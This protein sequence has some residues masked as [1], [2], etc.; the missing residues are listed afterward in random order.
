[1]QFLPTL[2]LL[3]QCPDKVAC[4]LPLRAPRFR[5]LLASAVNPVAPQDIPD[6]LPLSEFVDSLRYIASVIPM[7]IHLTHSLEADKTTIDHLSIPV[8]SAFFQRLTMPV[9]KPMTPVDHGCTPTR[10]PPVP[11]DFENIAQHQDVFDHS[12]NLSHKSHSS[13][14]SAGSSSLTGSASS[15]TT[16]VSSPTW[17]AKVSRTHLAELLDEPLASSTM[18]TFQNEINQLVN[19]PSAV[20]LLSLAKAQLSPMKPHIGL[21]PHA[22]IDEC[23]S[24]CLNKV[25]FVPQIMAHTERPLEDCSYLDKCY[26][27]KSCRFLHYQVKMPEHA[28]SPH[29]HSRGRNN[30]GTVAEQPRSYFYSTDP[31]LSVVLPPQW[32]TCNLKEIALPVFGD[33]AAIIADPPWD[34]HM[35]SQKLIINDSDLQALDMGCL[36]KEG[37]FLLWVTGR[38][39]EVGRKCLAKWGYT[40]VQEIVWCKTNQLGRTICTGRTGHWL[41]HSKEHV[42]IGVKGNPEWLTC[43]LDVDTVVSNARDKSQ[44]PDELYDIVERMVGRSSRK[45]ELFGRENNLR[46]GWLTVGSQLNGVNISEPDLA[47]R[48]ERWRV[49]N[50]VSIPKDQREGQHPPKEREQRELLSKGGHSSGH[51]S[52]DS[53]ARNNNNNNNKSR[54]MGRR[55]RT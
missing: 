55:R 15:C 39:S 11:L 28:G 34:I 12:P 40:D 29:R 18:F 36:Q 54:G 38:T 33:F 9:V 10:T 21:C 3:A 46:P 51:H 47:E 45:L 22:S 48:Y 24:D 2:M 50:H 5:L 23:S 14:S 31:M 41:N 53:P 25:R 26:K 16:M 17:S 27:S 32:I 43:G 1:M 19:E 49:A 13:F 44:K 52:K 4:M 8:L 30:S 7:G 20:F 6:L 35:N 42:L 37:V